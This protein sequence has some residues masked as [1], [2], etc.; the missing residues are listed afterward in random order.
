MTLTHA[1]RIALTTAGLAALLSTSTPANPIAEPLVDLT[2]GVLERAT[3]DGA[4][5]E[6]TGESEQARLRIVCDGTGPAKVTFEPV[7]GAWDLSDRTALGVQVTNRSDAPVTVRAQIEGPAAEQLTDTC[8]GVVQ[9]LPGQTK[10]LTVRLTRRPEDPTYAPFE[11]FYMY[12]KNLNVRDNTIAPAQVV[13][14]VLS[15]DDPQAGQ[16]V[17]FS[18]VRAVGEGEPAPVEFFPFV[19]AYGQY[20]HA[21][22]PGKIYDDG[23]FAKR[24]A[25]EAAE[26]EDWPGPANWNEYGG[27]AAGPQLEA[28][29]FFRVTKHDGKWWLV[30]PEGRLFWSY[31]PTG[32]GFGGDVTPITDREHWFASL[33]ETDSEL[34]Q[35]YRDSHDATYRYYEDRD[36]TGFDIQRA[37]LFRKYGPDY[38]EEVK[39]L[40]HQRMRSWGFNTLGNWSS[41]EVYLMQKTPYVVPIHYDARMMHYRMPDIYDAGWE[42][43]VREAMER[44]RETTAKD[45]WNIGYF[46]DNER[47]FGWRPRAAAIGEEALKNPAD[48]PV[49]LELLKD[50]KAKYGDIVALNEAWDTDHASWEALLRH[51]E[52]PDMENEAVIEDLG[53]FGMKFAEK[54]F[55]TIDRIVAEVAPNHMYLGSRFHG[56]IDDDVVALASKYADVISYNIYDNPPNGRVN[57]YNHLDVPILSTEWGIGS[58]PQQTPFRGS[59]LDVETP[60]ERAAKMVGY[61]ERAIQHPNLVGAHF[62]QFRDQPLSGRPDG[63]ATLRGFVNVADTPSFELVRAN[64]EFAYDLYEKRTKAE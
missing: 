56:H 10:Q 25:E 62:F 42:P 48:A 12:F 43:A 8:R 39:E 20:V 4:N 34:G 14:L 17:T 35:F 28:T 44:H 33:P 22:W 49:K 7:S 37:N 23:D 59:S 47:W 50:L 41:P 24:R 27:W 19:D 16:Q 18:D 55:S 38:E 3:V 52:T 11:P 32:V 58:D 57:Q 36:W 64:R 54:Y 46:V 40:S 63:E 15:V 45:P 51:R 5:A 53:D 13:R 60:A 21:D 61:A 26:R 30:D 9:L 1:A 31:G 2:P 29:G 6:L